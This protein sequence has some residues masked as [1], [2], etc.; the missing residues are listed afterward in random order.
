M[1]NIWVRTAHLINGPIFVVVFPCTC[2]KLFPLHMLHHY[3][4]IVHHMTSILH[5]FTRNIFLKIRNT[6]KMERRVTFVL[7]T[8]KTSCYKGNQVHRWKIEPKR[9]QLK[10]SPI[11]VNYSINLILSNNSTN[12]SLPSRMN[13]ICAYPSLM[14]KKIGNTPLG[15]IYLLKY[16]GGI[17]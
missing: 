10:L 15:S 6:Y 2:Q 3:I 1:V 9:Q 14:W 4:F 5:Y 11:A 12:I 8:T 7:I 17:L 13:C 16:F